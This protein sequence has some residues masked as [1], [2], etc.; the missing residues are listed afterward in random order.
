MKSVQTGAPGGIDVVEL[1]RPAPGPDDVLV[2]VRACGICG[3]D[4]GFLHLGGGPFG[5]GGQMIA[6][7]LG[8]EPVG[9]IV[10]VG[11]DVTGLK[12][13]DHVVVNP[14]AAP[15]G[16]I[17]CGGTLGGVREYL[18]IENAIVGKSLAV[19]P[20][21][22]PFDVAALNEPMAVA[23][24]CVNRSEARDIDRVVFGAGPIGLGVTIWLKLRGV[25]HVVVADVIASRLETA[26]AVGADAVIDSSHEDVTT[27]L[28]GPGQQRTTLAAASATGGSRLRAVSAED[29]GVAEG[30]AAR[31]WEDSEAVGAAAHLDSGEELPGRESDGVHNAVVAA[32]NP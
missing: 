29:A 14:Q 6:V 1:D 12:V 16:I 18:L 13:G 10:E 22:L 21:S 23:L 27:R 4:A 26:L 31:L 24:H 32:R 7:P 8:H 3:T 5:P 19:T 9:E 25:Q 20:E 11:A 30:V 15:S 28:L 17:G 2:R